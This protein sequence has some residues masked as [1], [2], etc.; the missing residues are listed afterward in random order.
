MARQLEE[1]WSYSLRVAKEE[2]ED[3]TKKELRH[4]SPEEVKPMIEEINTNILKSEE[5]IEA[6]QE[7]ASEEAESE[8]TEKEK[9]EKKKIK[10]KLKYCSKNWPK[11]LEKYEEQE[12]QLA[13]R[14]SMS[15]I[16]TD[17]TFM[18][19]KEDH[20]NKGELKAGYNVQLAVNEQII[21]EYGI[22]PNPTDTRTLPK[23][24]E[25]I[26]EDYQRT[27]SQIIAD[28]GYGSEENY[29]YLKRESIQGIIKYNTYEKEQKK[30]RREKKPFIAEKLHYNK[31]KNYYVCPMGQK[32]HSIG[33]TEEKNESGYIQQK[34]KY[35][36]ENCSGC[37]LRSACY[38]GRGNRVIEVNH[39]LQRLKEEVREVLQSE[40]GKRL[41]AKRKIEVEP[42]FGN[43]KQNKGFRRFMLRGKE[44]VNTEFGLI[45]IAHNL[46]KAIKFFTERNMAL[47]FK[48]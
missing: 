19:M 9:T 32:M 3:R 25:Q 44:K 1:L 28:A 2:S 15:R 35:R 7:S 46:S 27:P 13:G 38:K 4:L 47:E 11:N 42:V 43:I 5:E 14:K 17:A 22:Y 39:N 16:D 10:Q 23:F 40:E 21:V 30:V 45:A 34:E 20:M 12:E 36:A 24:V 6:E 29:E 31:E 18:R 48:F 8:K 41:Y 37:S 33:K 26:K